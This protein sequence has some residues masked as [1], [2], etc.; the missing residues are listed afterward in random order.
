MTSLATSQK[1]PN[2]LVISLMPTNKQHIKLLS[3]IS[4]II[5][6]KYTECDIFLTGSVF[7]ELR[8]NQLLKWNKR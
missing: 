6:M 4:K 5:K 7:R 3:L 8:R 1:R 2:Y